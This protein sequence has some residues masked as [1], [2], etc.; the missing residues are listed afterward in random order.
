MDLKLLLTVFTSVFVAELG[1]KTQLASLA[2]AGRYP[3]YAVW[4]GAAAG[5]VASSQWFF[6]FLR[7][8]QIAVSVPDA[9]VAAG[10]TCRLAAG[11]C[12]VAEACD[13]VSGV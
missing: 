13:G 10:T 2:L 3:W 11:I 6:S 8:E 12:D 5:M 4:P 7:E 1:D 9:V